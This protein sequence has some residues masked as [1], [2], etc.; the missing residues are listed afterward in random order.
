[1]DSHDVIKRP[2]HTEK[3]VADISYNNAYYFEVDCRACKSDIKQ[4]VEDLFEG[5]KVLS[6]RTVWMRGKGRRM[7]WKKGRTRD[8]KKAIVKLRPG[9]TIDMGY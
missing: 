5:V 9:D 3:S 2:L 7:R 4:A 1:V 6:V 8:K